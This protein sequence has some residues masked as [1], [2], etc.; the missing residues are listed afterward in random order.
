MAK[1]QAS[2]QRSTRLAP[3]R[4]RSAG[5]KFAPQKNSPSSNQDGPPE[6]F[7]EMLG[8]KKATGK[9]TQRCEKLFK[10]DAGPNL[11]DLSSASSAE[12]A[13][14]VY[15]ILG[16]TTDV[17]A[18]VDLDD[19]PESQGTA[20]EEHLKVFIDEELKRL[21]PQA[22][23]KVQ[24]N[25]SV[26]SFQQYE[27]L[28]KIR[29]LLDRKEN[30]EL[31][32]EIGKDYQV[33]TDV[34]VSVPDPND[35]RKSRIL[36]AAVSSKLTI[37]SD[38]VQNIRHEFST[39]I[40]TRNG[41]L[42]HLVVVTAEP[43]PSRLKSIAQGTGE[44]DCIYHLLFDEMNQAINDLDKPS[45]TKSIQDQIDD[46]K[47]LVGRGRIRPIREMLKAIAFN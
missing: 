1:R 9:T 43:M 41:R 47:E 32:I 30:K 23:W 5:S 10:V 21:R 31:K 27:H 40:R 11:A 34:M 46:W 42:P 33:K 17:I 19:D 26:N 28:E 16:I 18:K 35:A 45:A 38:R 7:V 44:A 25:V 6:W 13:G 29:D 8:W 20:L 22:G 37:R 15:A 3:T 14:R 12:I 36:H 24:R 4:S 2:G 39:L